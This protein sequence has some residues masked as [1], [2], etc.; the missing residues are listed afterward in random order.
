MTVVHGSATGTAV[1]VSEQRSRA[2][3]PVFVRRTGR[4]AVGPFNRERHEVPFILVQL[5]GGQVDGLR[6]RPVA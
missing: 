6:A 2:Q 5:V 1:M 4:R 3:R